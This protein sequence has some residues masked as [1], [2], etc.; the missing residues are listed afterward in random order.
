MFL[1]QILAFVLAFSVSGG[2]PSAKTTVAFLT[3]LP[4]PDAIPSLHPSWDGGPDVLP[5][6]ELAVEM[7][8]NRTDI[9]SEYNLVLIND[10]GGCDIVTKAFTSIGHRVTLPDPNR[11]IVGIIGPSCSSSTLAVAPVSGREELAL[12]NVHIGGSPL[13]QD[14]TKH[15]YAYGM[16]DSSYQYVQTTYALMRRNN[17]KQVS[18]LYEETRTYFRSLFQVLQRDLGREIPV[19]KLPFSSA[20]YDTYLPLATI[21]EQLL[22]II[23]VFTGSGFANRI[24]CLAYHQDMVFPAYQFVLVNRGI[25]EFSRNVSFS[26]E[27]RTYKCSGELMT[28]LAL[29]GNLFMLN[30]LIPFERNTRTDS[31]LTYI[32]YLQTYNERVLKH[33]SNPNNTKISVNIWGTTFFDATWAL[34]LALNASNV[35]LSAYHYGNTAAAGTIRE[36]FNNLHFSGVSADLI[37]FD[38]ETGFLHRVT[39]IFQA[40]NGI[41]NYVAYH[42]SSHLEE[43]NISA[44]YIDDTFETVP[45]TVLPPV[46]GLFMFLTTLQFLMII[47]THVI[48]IKYRKYQSIKA[49][50]PKLNHFVYAG[51]YGI[52]TGALLFMVQKV[53]D[54]SEETIGNM[55]QAIWPWFFSIGFTLTFAPILARTWRLYRIFTHF[56]NPGNLISEPVLLI[57]VFVFLLPDV[58]VAIVWTAIDPFHLENVQM[59]TVE[60][61]QGQ[62]ILLERGCTCDYY[63]IWFFII[64]GYKAML[65]LVM[66]VLG[67]LT[68]N[69][70]SR[71]F[72]TKSLRVFIYLLAI[73]FVLGG[74]LYY[75]TAFQNLDVHIDYV[76]L[77]TTL[78][79]VIFLY[80]SFIFLPPVLPLLKEKYNHFTDQHFP[81]ISS[82]D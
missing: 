66:V 48:T 65:I 1:F 39:D 80:F 35:N 56:T 68:R 14:R 11:P 46:A 20:V 47:A 59:F 15:P 6:V 63:F 69:I 53:L 70:L 25:T 51:S 32:E 50:S 23:F 40:F 81:I 16:L 17:W 10:D 34:A 76:I 78:N 74:S 37:S 36:K 57:V 31:G 62:T 45:I 41:E 55:C 52:I 44:Y 42:N 75:I 38:N 22:R 67:Q 30:K 21:R 79:I 82:H 28:N 2:E 43:F 24:I 61:E 7:I 8:N 64:Y 58:V 60:D 12:I 54:F 3:L 77:C 18:V 29:R 4:Y 33:N 19:G 13:I 73:V 26:Y 27:G 71:D 5:V 9:L 72:T 49:S